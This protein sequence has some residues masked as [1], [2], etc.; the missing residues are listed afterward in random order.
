MFHGLTAYTT[1]QIVMFSAGILMCLGAC[2]GIVTSLAKEKRLML[3]GNCAT[4]T[5]G[6]CFTGM[7]L[8]QNDPKRLGLVM[9]LTLAV[10]ISSLASALL[11]R[12]YAKSAKAA[13]PLLPPAAAPADSIWPPPPSA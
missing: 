10:I 12:A 5:T 11:F 9:L 4:L 3:G 8:L 7:S 2:L 6:L 1:P 13:A